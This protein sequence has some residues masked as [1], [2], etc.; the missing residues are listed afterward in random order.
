M[1]VD[2]NSSN[3][4]NLMGASSSKE[5]DNERDLENFTD[6]ED[7]GS[8]YD[9]DTAIAKSTGSSS[10]ST[11]E[12]IED[13]NLKQTKRTERKGRPKK[14][15]NAKYLGQTFRNRKK[16]KDSNKK[17]YSIK[18]KLIK[19]KIFIDFLCNCTLKCN[20]SIS[21]ENRKKVFENFWGLASYNAQT[22]YIA[23]TV[24]QQGIK[25]KRNK[26]ST[27]RQYTRVYE[28]SN[29][30]V[31]RDMYIK[32]LHISPK[33]VNTALKKIKTGSVKDER[34]FIQGGH[35]KLSEETKNKVIHQISK[36]PT[37][38]SHYTRNES[39]AKYSVPDHTLRKMYHL[40]TEDELNHKLGFSSYKTIP[41]L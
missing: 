5:S 20:E 13:E 12:Q 37:Y 36:F 4:N 28:I 38:I 16:L 8:E 6:F 30:K 34:G 3:E 19:P 27:R 23:A 33:R 17:H 29:I 39:D 25:R 15:R 21:Q 32:T 14:G 22:A 24:R 18:G 31:C 7:S 1:A 2:N 40:Y 10:D 9:P 35:I 41:I 26:Q 11:L